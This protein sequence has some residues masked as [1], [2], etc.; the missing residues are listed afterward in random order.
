M[1]RTIP[2]NLETAAIFDYQ[3]E[4]FVEQFGREP[5]PDDPIFFDPDFD[6]PVE[7]SAARL[8]DVFVKASLAAGVIKTEGEATNLLFDFMENGIRVSPETRAAVAP[9]AA[10]RLGHRGPGGPEQ[11]A[12][13]SNGDP[14][15]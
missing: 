6:M 10:E 15:L 12:R 11:V 9:W 8:A 14:K 1:S 7:M 2:I 13:K 3:R 4:Q 5:G